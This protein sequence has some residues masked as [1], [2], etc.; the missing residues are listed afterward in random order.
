MLPGI[1]NCP[2]SQGCSSS[3]GKNRNVGMVDF[4]FAQSRILGHTHLILV[5]CFYFVCY[6]CVAQGKREERGG[7]E[8]GED[9]GGEREN[10]HEGKTGGRFWS[11]ALAPAITFGKT[12]V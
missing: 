2:N 7:R 6:H 1:A 5:F 3:P 8:T 12:T 11:S 10:E 9:R 4:S